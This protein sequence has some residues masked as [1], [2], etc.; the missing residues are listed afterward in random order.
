MP[1]G[2]VHSPNTSIDYRADTPSPPASILDESEPHM[3][4][5]QGEPR[6]LHLSQSVFHQPK[7]FL[8]HS[9]VEIDSDDEYDPHQF[10]HENQSALDDMDPP[11]SLLLDHETSPRRGWSRLLGG[12]RIPTIR[13]SSPGYAALEADRFPVANGRVLGRD[14]AV[15][16]WDN[17]D[18]LDRFLGRVY[19]YFVGKGIWTMMLERFCNLLYVWSLQLGWLTRKRILAF[20][21]GFSIFIFNCVDYSQIESGG[22]LSG[23]V[24]KQCLATIHILPL[25]FLCLFSIWWIIQAIRMVLQVPKLWEMYNFYTFVLE[26]PDVDMQSVSWATVATRLSRL[27]PPSKLIGSLSMDV[28]SIASRI[29]RRE[30]YVIAM[31]NEPGLLDLNVYGFGTV[32][33]ASLEWNL[34]YCVLGYLFDDSGTVCNGVT[35]QIGRPTVRPTD[36]DRLVAGYVY[37]KMMT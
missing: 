7:S 9:N 20:V 25:S 23:I 5:F 30:N 17:V 26:I 18:D 12:A 27:P 21:V 33:T 15:R 22:T 4:S 13:R 37:P 34:H 2:M 29:M 1:P 3:T 31:I 35:S 16:A 32:L 14:A 36:H 6:H 10:L 11:E 8:V 24:E 19:T 28:L